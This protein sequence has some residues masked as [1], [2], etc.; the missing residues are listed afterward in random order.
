M[1][2]ITVVII[3]IAIIILVVYYELRLKRAKKEKTSLGKAREVL[4]ARAEERKRRILEEVKERGR[5]TN[6]QVQ[7]LLGVSDA[8]ATNYLDSLE[9]EGLIEQVGGAKRD[10]YYKIKS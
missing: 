2:I 5:V 8:T 1:K 7:K 9:K 4:K 3:A 6:N 10:T